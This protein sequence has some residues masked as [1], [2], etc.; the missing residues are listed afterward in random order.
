M[1]ASAAPTEVNP[2]YQSVEDVSTMPEPGAPPIPKRHT[3][4]LA[5][6]GVKVHTVA[7]PISPPTS[8]PLPLL[9]HISECITFVLV[10]ELVYS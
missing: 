10:V 6:Q 1:P 9:S 2:D 4:K 5:R 3:Q 8:L 7:P